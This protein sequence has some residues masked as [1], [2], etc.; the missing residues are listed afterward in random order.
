LL[1]CLVPLAGAGAAW[2][3]TFTN[4]GL[5]IRLSGPGQV[6]V[7]WD[8]ATNAAYRLETCS[9]LASNAWAPCTTDWLA[10]DGNRCCTNLPLLADQARF[11][12]VAVTN[13][14][15]EATPAPIS[16]SKLFG[17]SL[18][19]YA[20]AV[21]PASDG[22]YIVAGYSGSIDG[23]A[24]ENH[25][26][27]DGIALK[28]DERGNVQWV[29][30]LGGS[31][32]DGLLSVKPTADGGYICAGCVGSNNGDVSGNHGALD[33]WLVKLGTNGVI[34]WQ[35]CFGGTAEDS[36]NSV[37]QTAD[38]GYIAAGYT[39]S[40]NGD[41]AGN[42]GYED[43]WVVKTDASGNLQWR[44]CLG[45]TDY[46]EFKQ[47][48]QTTDGGYIFAGLTYSTDG[49]VSG[50]HGGSD[51]WV[52]KLNTN[53]VVQ[54]Q[55][56]MGGSDDDELWSV[57]QTPDGGYI[58]AGLTYSSDG[59]ISHNSGGTDCWVVK[60]DASGNTQWQKT[61]GG[62]N[63]D[64]LRSIVR[65]ADGGYIATGLESSLDI[66]GW[67]GA[68]DVYVC[69]LDA[70]GEIQWQRC[71]GGSDW[72]YGYAVRQTGDGGYI[73]AGPTDSDDGD[74]LAP[75]GGN[76]IW[77]IKLLPN[78]LTFS[79]ASPSFHD[80]FQHFSYLEPWSLRSGNWAVT[81]GVFRVGPDA[82][83]SFAAAYLTNSWPY[84]PKL[85]TNYWSS[86]WVEARVQLESGAGGGGLAGGLDPTTGARYAAWICPENS[87]GG[88]NVLK[89]LK[90]QDWT[91][92]SYGGVAG[93]PM[94][95][96]N[97][98][99]VGTNWHTLK[100]AFLG[101]QIDVYADGCRRLSVTDAEAQPYPGGGVSLDFWTATT[102]CQMWADDVTVSPLVAGETCSVYED[103]P[104]VMPATGVLANDLGVGATN[105]TATLVTGPT[106]GSVSLAAN[107]GFTYTPATNYS[108]PDCFVYS[109]SNGQTNL[110]TAAVLITVVPVND[111]PVL[112][113]QNDRTLAPLTTLTVTNTATDVDPPSATTLTYTL[114]VTNAAG[115]VTNASISSQGII[116]WTPTV[117]RAPSLNAFTTRVTDGAA[118]ATNRFNVT[119]TP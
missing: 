71:M 97:L 10:G 1:L 46:D 94:Q 92:Y 114:S 4:V 105:L 33:A 56:V 76:D 22:G 59:D 26:G 37:W 40:T 38:G 103:T 25:D 66:P 102:P 24:M 8:T 81:N 52:V 43:A 9:S 27:Y 64:Q 16:W 100:L 20:Y 55:R 5:A 106:N 34:Q 11:Y 95:Q 42:H 75:L 108:G 62:K 31:Q 53:G 78:G 118:S 86:F 47:I 79:P 45:G 69:K 57:Q 63:Y 93:Q 29:K 73:V 36:F 65:T 48:Q 80:Y 68:Y 74:I 110:G 98:P 12:R 67:H 23:D 58:L 111:A 77:V 70:Q 3:D 87:P 104:F 6:E 91:N 112:P 14:P 83:S 89:L 99:S 82:P 54:W 101:A 39:Y 7:S 28:L 115:A 30:M 119:V 117:A 90:F 116:T 17:G 85:A 21:E 35:K 113:P 18:D 51:G 88:S 19:D 49:D 2:G 32:N 84:F 15:A 41:V 50:N 96:T 44:K 72:D 13:G 60:L 109:V 61:I 107:G